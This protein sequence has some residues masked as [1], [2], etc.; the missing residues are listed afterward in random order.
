[1]TKDINAV[2]VGRILISLRGRKLN[3]S[4]LV[5]WPL[6]YIFVTRWGEAVQS[7]ALFE[8]PTPP[9]AERRKA[10]QADGYP[11]STAH[12]AITGDIQI[13][14]GCAYLAASHCRGNGLGRGT[15]PCRLCSGPFCGAGWL[16]AWLVRCWR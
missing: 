8:E 5:L 7:G 3:P 6:S 14:L 4:L 1:V 2:N 9:A 15:G 16:A 11:S 10:I 12:Q 13:P